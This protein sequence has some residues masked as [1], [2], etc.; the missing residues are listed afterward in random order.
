MAEKIL[1]T[2]IQLKYDTLTNWTNSTFTLK[3]GEI[4]IV[5]V[6]TVEGSTLQPV[7]FK[8]GDG[9]KTFSQLDWASAKA[10][11]V[12]GWAKKSQTDFET[13]VKGLINTDVLVNYYTKTEID[14]LLEAITSAASTLAGRVTALEEKYDVDKKL[15]VIISELE[16]KIS[17]VD[18]G[19]MSITG[20]NAIAVSEGD[21]PKVSLVIDPTKG[22]VEL[23]QSAT[24]L[25]ANVDLSD[26]AL[27]EN[28]PTEE[29]IKTLAANEIGR[30]ID[31]SGDAET[32]KS[33]GDLVDYAEKNAGD[34]AQLVTDVAAANTNASNAVATANG[35]NTTA[36]QALEKANQALE[37]AE[38]AVAAKTAAEAA[39]AK[40]EEAQG[41]AETAQQAAET[42][43][44]LAE[45][46]KG[47]AVNA[48]TAAETAQ[49]AAETAQGKA[50]DAQ[51]A[52]E[53][54]VATAEGHA[55]TASTKA[56]EAAASATAAAGSEG[57]AKTSEDNAL[58]S[59]NAA[60]GSAADA[61]ASKTAAATSESNAAQSASDA[62]DA[63]AAA[64]QAKEDANT[65][66]GQVTDA[67]TGAQ[68]TA[69]EAKTIAQGANTTA[70]EAKT[71]AE[72]AVTTANEA[73]ATAGTAL[74]TVAAGD[75]IKVTEKA[76]NSQTVSIDDTI[77]WVFDCGNASDKINPI[78]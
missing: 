60:A 72:G 50:E 36:G 75:G 24:G 44:G 6:P 76:D 53:A 47:E 13:Y 3:K 31:A 23:T 68:A 22:N 29:E 71:T 43:Q 4:A 19:V 42:A 18:T 78:A 11:D 51:E 70:G 32:L 20:E 39:Q 12:Y 66:L 54:A 40:A 55:S 59:A 10:A 7:M 14:E 27:S 74:Q 61:L 45:T 38:G 65:I 25:K 8:V 58:A 64:V 9:T 77:V 17:A 35:A 41:K 26:Y 34:I 15:S 63:K 16:G 46:A 67:A 56:G 52:A 28:V 49:G 73:K 48:Q 5:E 69:N 1:N 37:G 57:R 21:N 30:L 2:R 62:N 33:I